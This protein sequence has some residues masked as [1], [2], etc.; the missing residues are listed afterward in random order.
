MAREVSRARM[1][2]FR[3]DKDLARLFVEKIR[4]CAETARDLGY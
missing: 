1:Q 2:S 3:S 4:G